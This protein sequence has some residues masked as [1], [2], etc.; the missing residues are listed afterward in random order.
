MPTAT[1]ESATTIVRENF[2][3]TVVSSVRSFGRAVGVAQESVT[4]AAVRS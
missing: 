4:G 2:S 3:D 1:S